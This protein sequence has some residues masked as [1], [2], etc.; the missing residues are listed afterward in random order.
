MLAARY[1]VSKS[2]PYRWNMVRFDPDPPPLEHLLLP[3]SYQ[4]FGNIMPYLPP[5]RFSAQLYVSD[6]CADNIANAAAQFGRILGPA[7]VEQQFNTLKA[8]WTHGLSEI[9][10]TVWPVGLQSGGPLKNE[11]HEREPRLKTACSVEILSGWRAGLTSYE[12]HWLAHAT[13]LAPICNWPREYVAGISDKQRY[14]VEDALEFIR[15]APPDIAIAAGHFGLSN[16]GAVLIV[17]DDLLYIVPVGSVTEINLLRVLPAKGGGWSGMTVRC[18]TGNDG[19]AGKSIPV[20]RGL[21][22]DDLTALAEQFA[23]KIGKPLNI[24]PYQYDA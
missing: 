16:D 7:P 6:N 4:E 14:L 18:A 10:L 13:P 20:A 23:Y 8:V 5:V 3:F 21:R 2:N 11:A 15:I 22:A 1:G 24:H 17:N 9:S 12:R 19:K